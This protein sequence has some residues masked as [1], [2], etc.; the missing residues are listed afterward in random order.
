MDDLDTLATLLTKPE[1][2]TE[3]ITRSRNRLQDRTRGRARRRIGWLMPGVGLATAA[4]A[5][6][7]VIATGVTTPA[8]A[9]V[10]GRE[11]LLMAAAGAERTPQGSGTY[12]YVRSEWSDP[13]IPAMESW[14]RRDG[15][16]WTKGEPGDPPG[17]AVPTTLPL[18]L[19]GAK[20]SFEDLEGLPTDP[21]ALKAW[22]TER[23]GRADDM[24]RSE[25]RGDPL[26]PLLSLISE[27]PTP[28]EVRSAAFRA[29]ATTPGVESGGAVEGG[30][31]LLIPNPEGG[32]EIKLVVDPETARVTRTNYL[33][34]GDGNVAGTDEFISVTTNW[35]D[36]PPR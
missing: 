10:S 5:V 11:V 14:T 8:G 2:S 21:E 18:S 13:E 16:R 20:V 35:T 36:Q 23:K 7:A 19:K 22:I 28:S 17:V 25:Q 27:L 3:A 29:L 24:S 30:Q 1:P 6:V 9:P 4:A 34:S 26:F 31:E 12:W 32:Q 33:L 15:R